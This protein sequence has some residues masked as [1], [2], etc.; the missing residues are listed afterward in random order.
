M[1]ILSI[2]YNSVDAG[3]PY[4]VAE[5]YKN[6]LQKNNF[7]VIMEKIQTTYFID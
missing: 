5:I 6:I 4:T 1:K 3:G 2:G 7:V